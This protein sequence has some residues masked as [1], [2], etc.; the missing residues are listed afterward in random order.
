M[1]ITGVLLSEEQGKE[2]ISIAQSH[3][4]PARYVFRARLIL[5]L[6]E[7]ATFSVIQKQLRTMAPTIKGALPS[8]GGWMGWERITPVS[9]RAC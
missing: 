2:L 4:L 8:V 6:A 3:S 9:R 1:P 5:M 7:R